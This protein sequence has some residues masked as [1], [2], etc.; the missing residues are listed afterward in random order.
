[1]DKYLVGRCPECLAINAAAIKM[2]FDTEKSWRTTR[3]EFEG[4]NLIVSELVTNERVII[5]G[6]EEGCSIGDD[7]K[8]RNC[9]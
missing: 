5:E 9:W 4:S 1:M 2:D 7:R 6:C 3:E 8:I